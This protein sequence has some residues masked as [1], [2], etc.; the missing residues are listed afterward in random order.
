[1]QGSFAMTALKTSTAPKLVVA[2]L[3]ATIS[4]AALTPAAFAAGLDRG[5][6]DG[7]RGE[8]HAHGKGGQMGQMRQMGGRGGQFLAIGCSPNAAERIETGLVSLGYR[9]DATAEQKALLDT[10]KTAALDAQ[11]ELAA[12]CESVMPAMAAAAPADG[13]APAATAPA[14]RPNLLERLQTRH[15]IDQA[16]VA[17]MG[18]VLPQF[19]AFFNSLTDEQKASLEPRRHARDGRNNDGPRGDRGRGMNRH[20]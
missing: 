13:V 18:D 16:R 17:A 20:R 9:V 3:A 10:L 4:F 12:V 15:A 6:R 2:I 1:M 7:Q 5:G 19:E 8:M 14:E 11:T